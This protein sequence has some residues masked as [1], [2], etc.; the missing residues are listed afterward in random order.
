[1]VLAINSVTDAKTV[2]CESV[3][4]E[5]FVTKTCFMDKTTMIDEN[6]ETIST[7][8]ESIGALSFVGNR[9]IFYLPIKVAE[10]LPNLLVYA[11]NRCSVIDVSKDHFKG[12][13]KLKYLWLSHNQ[14]EKIPS[15]TFEDLPDLEKLWLSEL[16][17]SDFLFFKIFNFKLFQTTTKS[18]PSKATHFVA[19]K[20]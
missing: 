3:S 4:S 6:N 12:L 10:N 15:R 20:V 13:S 16:I 18:N 2:Q 17:A 5:Y 19:S 8:D 14:I 1:M 11:A 7:E 9:N